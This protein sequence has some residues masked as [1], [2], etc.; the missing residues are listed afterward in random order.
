MD[1]RIRPGR[2]RTPPRTPPGDTPW[3]R[4]AERERLDQERREQERRD[5]DRRDRE[6]RERDRE[7][8]EQDRRERARARA[9]DGRPPVP[10]RRRPT[11]PVSVEDPTR[12]VGP[13]VRA[14]ADRAAADRTATDRAATDRAAD[15]AAR[16]A[17][18]E[19]DRGE[20]VTRIT[21]PAVP[22]RPVD[23][24]DDLRTRPVRQSPPS[25]T[26]PKA[27]LP[28]APPTKAPPGKAAG[29]KTPLAKAAPTGKTPT[30]PA[31]GSRPAGKASTSTPAGAVAASAAAEADEPGTAR[32]ERTGGTRRPTPP[33]VRRTGRRRPRT[34]GRA[35]LTTAAAAVAP[36]SGHLMLH[37]RRTGWLILGPFLFLVV[38][39][40]LLL[41][42]QRRSTLLT[43]LLSSSGLGLAAAGCVLAALAWIAV[44]V[45]TWLISQP[46]GL[47]STRRTVGVAVTT[48]LCLLVAA[49]FGFAANLANS[50]RSVLGELFTDD[51]DS[52]AALGP[53]VN[54]LLVGSDAGPDRTGTRTDTMMV[55][56]I[57]TASGRT[58]LFSLPRNIAYAQFPP[59][60]PMA[61][62]FPDGFH[63]S[64]EPSGNYYL[65][66]VYA[67]GHEHPDLAPTT[68]TDDPG[69]N[70]LH[71]TVSYM[72]GLELDYYVELNM[73]GFAAI[74]DSLGG[75]RVDVGPERIPI[76]GI[77]PTGRAVTPTG[78]IEPGVQQL[79]GEDALAF[80]RSRT[81]STDYVRMGRQR[82]LIQNILDQNQPAELLTNFQSIARATTDSVSTDIPQQALP[83]LLSIAD[84]PIQL[85]SVAFDPN[86]PD[87]DQ[88]DGRFNTGDPDFDLMKQ[89]VQDAINRDP[90]A[91]PPTVAA[92]PSAIPEAN[93]ADEDS[94]TGDT[95]AEATSDAPLTSTPVSVAQ[96]C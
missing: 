42:T 27:P 87:P 89:V 83:A 54:L 17:R 24:G 90:A 88:S 45:R 6:R 11:E 64:A 43:P 71:Q 2:D 77:S 74:I 58:T 86:L 75:V 13:R 1:E 39:L 46:R 8:R 94:E 19:R 66:A 51:A 92:A 84:A 82:C 95:G 53:R 76:G 68:P 78:Y 26:P 23:D 18:R 48:A 59:G 21:R 70:L 20:P 30:T 34:L 61:E 38:A 44:I 12:P 3:P 93:E 60:S 72:L 56:S 22:R 14:A 55:A 62:E 16:R 31:G 80:A 28:A 29:A 37:R 36:G 32:P 81:N 69:L 33:P 7:R 4:R 73:A 15:S 25:A 96:S 57:D 5:R 91:T 49:P 85:E 67:Y 41:A 50:S 40:L 9:A 65:N 10:P 47:D 35:L 79:G 52:A 63:D